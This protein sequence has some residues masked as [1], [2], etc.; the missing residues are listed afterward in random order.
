MG[1]LSE[2]R[3]EE[4]LDSAVHE[5]GTTSSSLRRRSEMKPAFASWIIKFEIRDVFRIKIE[6]TAH[7]DYHSFTTTIAPIFF[8]F[9]FQTSEK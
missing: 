2:R 3:F 8:V 4:Q 1:G 7:C 6:K 5:V 9:F